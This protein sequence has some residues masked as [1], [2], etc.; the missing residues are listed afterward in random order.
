MAQLTRLTSPDGRGPRAGFRSPAKVAVIDIGSHSIHMVIAKI[1]DQRFKITSRI[2]EPV[3][4]GYGT[5]VE[6]RLSPSVMAAGM[7]ALAGMIEIAT[8]EGVDAILPVATSAIR[9][10]VNGAEFIRRARVE[11]GLVVEVISGDEEARLIFRA[12]SQAMDIRNQRVLVADIGGGSV[13]L[14]QALG[15]KIE[16]QTSLKLGAVRMTEHFI[17]SDPPEPMEICALRSY[18]DRRLR[19]FALRAAAHRPAMMIATSGTFRSL[20][21]MAH[22][23]RTGESPRQLHGQT[24]GRREL[25][26]LRAALCGQTAGERERTSGLSPRRAGVIVAGALLA[27]ALMDSFGQRV[28]RLSDWALREGVILEFMELSRAAQDS[29]LHRA[30]PDGRSPGPRRHRRPRSAGRRGAAHNNRPTAR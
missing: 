6:G 17:E 27:E 12:V 23:K 1:R 19:P 7:D 26:V 30:S 10:A 16:W 20:A 25:T 24:L 22:A 21:A 8:R 9:E 18:V 5:L 29:E 3:G 2:R 14:V 13:E 15:S 28:V 11:L 4:L